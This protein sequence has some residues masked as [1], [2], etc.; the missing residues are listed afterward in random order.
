MI[1]QCSSLLSSSG[2]KSGQAATGWSGSVRSALT[3]AARLSAVY[4]AGLVLET[5]GEVHV[6]V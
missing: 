3:W 6:L 2:L 5:T 1:L 4:A